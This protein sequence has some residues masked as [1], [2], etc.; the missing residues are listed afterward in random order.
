MIIHGLTDAEQYYGVE[1]T[2]VKI[3]RERI[4]ER[5]SQDKV[6][7]VRRENLRILKYCIAL[8]RLR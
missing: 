2:I 8:Q 1:R 7:A 6:A 3:K 5:I 4:G